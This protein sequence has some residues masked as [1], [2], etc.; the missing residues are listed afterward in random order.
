MARILVVDDEEAVRSLIARGLALDSHTV[1]MAGDGAEALEM[2]TASEGR[3]DLVLSDIRMPL[4]DGIAM[5]LA[6]KRDFPDL[7]IL[8]MTGYA[9]QRERAKSLEN[10]VIDV[11]TKPFGLAELRS[12]VARVLEQTRKA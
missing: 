5:A 6:A 1:E 7:V 8:L 3:F 4:M 12:T 2:I 10:I 11:L 9:E